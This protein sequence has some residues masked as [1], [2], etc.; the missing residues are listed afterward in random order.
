MKTLKSIFSFIS[1]SARVSKRL[2]LG[3]SLSFIIDFIKAYFLFRFVSEGSLFLG[4]V[5]KGLSLLKLP[6]SLVLSSAGYAISL[7]TGRFIGASILLWN[8]EYLINFEEQL[9]KKSLSVPYQLLEQPRFLDLQNRALF[10]L[11]NQYCLDNLLEATAKSVGPIATIFAAISWIKKLSPLAMLL[12]ALCFAASF[13]LKLKLAKKDEGFYDE[14]APINRKNH[15]FESV[16]LNKEQVLDVK[17]CGFIPLINRKREELIKEI[18]VPFKKYFKREGLNLSIDEALSAVSC[19]IILLFGAAR[20]FEGRIDIASFNAFFAAGM[21]LSLAFREYGEQI[22]D[23]NRYGRYSMP[24]LELM[25]LG[26]RV[27]LKNEADPG[28]EGLNAENLSFSYCESGEKTLKNIF[29]SAKKPSVIVVVGE[30]G[31]G[32]STIMKLL[33]GLYDNFEGELSY[34]GSRIDE[35]LSKDF[36]STVF[37][38]F[39]LI[40]TVSIRDN[41]ACRLLDEKDTDEADKKIADI[42]DLLELDCAFKPSDILG[43]QF[44]NGFKELSSGQAQLVAILRAVYNNR[45]ILIL[46][47]PAANLDVEKER[48]LYK[49]IERLKEGRIIFLVSH[50]MSAV[51]EADEIWVLKDGEL[52]ARGSHKE[53]MKGCTYYSRLYTTQEKLYK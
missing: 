47:E 16:S 6:S 34:N 11:R 7:I 32:K 4:E 49:S 53:L 23:I 13:I 18:S 27:E 5:T 14:L 30:N 37:Q 36:V 25:S 44:G 31:A 43:S 26:G 22:I 51:H 50:R 12:L 28:K 33:S 38:D 9:L 52:I 48:Q 17:S 21:S 3:L 41:I 45:E 24:I 40:K 1:L 20:L 10:A 35:G 46:D 2:T 29:F 19:L 42:I 39:S 15:Y 8:Q